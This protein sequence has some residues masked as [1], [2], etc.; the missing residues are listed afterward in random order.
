MWTKE[1]SKGYE[2]AKCRYR[3]I[4]LLSEKTG[5]DLGCGDEKVVPTAIGIDRGGKA[6]NLKAD[7]SQPKALS[8]FSDKSFDYVFSSHLLEDLYDTEGILKEWWRLV[9][10][11]GHLI[12]YLPHKDFYPNIGQ[13]GANINHKHDFIGQDILDILDKFASYKLISLTNHNED[14]EYS[15]ELIVQKLDTGINQVIINEPEDIKPK[16]RALV[17]RYGGIGD[18][19]IITPLLKLLKQDGYHVTVNTIPKSECVLWDN[20]NV[21]E[22]M[23]QERGLVKAT[24]LDEYFKVISKGY[25]KF[26]N[27]CESLE[28]SLLFEEKDAERWNLPHEERHRLANVN[29]YDRTLDMGGYGQFKGFNGEIYLSDEEEALCKVFNK[30]HEGKFKI[31]WCLKG[32]SD[33]KFYPHVETVIDAILAKYENVEFFLVGGQEMTILTQWDKRIFNRVNIWGYRQSIIMTKYMDLVVSPETGVLNAVGCFDT[34]KIALLTHSSVENITKYFKNC[35]PL[36]ADCECH[37]CHK[38]VHSLRSCPLGK[39]FGLPICMEGIKPETV[40][41]A[42]EETYAK[43]NHR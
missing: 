17:V 31:M 19:I 26:I 10:P 35:T 36:E 4:S 38:L 22:I 20:P 32:S 11:N 2:S 28:C 13:P 24:K 8:F 43:H 34:P 27:L 7:L 42:I 14:D 23:L 9:K 21:D 3:I 1:K 29:Y 33:H 15:F 6:V 18:L 39:E 12:L 37:P 5:I 41:K 30:K 40:I 25:D 16:K